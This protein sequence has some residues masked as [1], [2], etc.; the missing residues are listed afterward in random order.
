MFSWFRLHCIWF[1]FCVLVGRFLNPWDEFF[2]DS[3]VFDIWYL[4]WHA[5][6]IAKLVTGGSLPEDSFMRKH[7]GKFSGHEYGHF[8]V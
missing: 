4:A 2:L 6:D 5:K 1:C 7:Y 8:K 3:V